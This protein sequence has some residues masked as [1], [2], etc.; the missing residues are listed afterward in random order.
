[1]LT[2]GD[3][4]DILFLKQLLIFGVLML[5]KRDRSDILFL[6]QKHKIFSSTFTKN[7]ERE[8]RFALIDVQFCFTNYLMFVIEFYKITSNLKT[9]K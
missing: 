3:R 2:K 1:M 6:K 8:A 9:L 7:I 4:S 5:T